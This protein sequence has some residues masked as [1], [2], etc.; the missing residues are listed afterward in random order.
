MALEF[1]ENGDLSQILDEY[2]L[3]EEK[4]AKF[5]IAELIL[6]MRHLHQKGIL[7]RDLKPEN[8]LVDSEGHL[9][10]ADFGLAH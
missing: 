4:T 2:S 8:I 5:L 3:I 9:K 7:F 6:G 10:L 1:C